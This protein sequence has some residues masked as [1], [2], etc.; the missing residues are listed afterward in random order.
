MELPGFGNR[1]VES[2]AEIFRYYAKVETPR[3]DSRV[4]ELL[5]A[6]VAEDPAIL[7]LCREIPARQPAPNVLFAAVQDLLMEQA[8]ARPGREPGSSARSLARFYPAL[9]GA[10][11]PDASPWPDFRAFCLENRERLVPRLRTGRTQT[12]VVHRCAVILPAL[13]TLP[14]IREAGSR[15][16]LLEIGPSAGL[17]LRLDRYRYDYGGGQVWGAP[18]ARPVL[19][20]ERR[21]ANAQ[22]PPG[23]LDVVTRR[24]VDLDPIDLEDPAA[25]RWLRALVWPEHAW[26]LRQMD[27]ALAHAASTPVEIEAGDA[28]REIG[29]HV[30]RLPR[31]AA[32]VVFA[33][34]VLYQIP[35]EGRRRLREALAEASRERPVD[36]VSMESTGR[37]DSELRWLGFE[38][39]E[40]RTNEVLARADSHGRWLEWGEA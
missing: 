7:E 5:S 20:C 29:R 25:V 28:T 18:E 34:H 37:G 4:Y 3:L 21:G 8:D 10:P 17:N 26:R 23:K 12:C 35:E 24:G 31:D 1:D 33:T 9:A 32:R 22:P 11:I 39:G 6:G 27:E 13:A 30:A 19:A 2:L 16:A 38:D 15:V 40:R 14:R 36:F